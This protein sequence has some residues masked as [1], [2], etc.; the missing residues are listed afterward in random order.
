MMSQATLDNF[1]EIKTEQ[2]QNSQVLVVILKDLNVAWTDRDWSL[3][4][5]DLVYL[6]DKL[7]NI[8][9]ERGIAR[10]VEVPS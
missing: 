7:A 1:V 2:A 5:Q 9:I 8:L 10:K 4:S 6:D 3:R